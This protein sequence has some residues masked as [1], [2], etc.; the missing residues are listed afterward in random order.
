MPKIQAGAR[1]AEA[2]FFAMIPTATATGWQPGIRT[3][4]PVPPAIADSAS[5]RM[6]GRG[7][8]SY[9]YRRSTAV[10][11]VY[12]TIGG[13]HGCT[14]IVRRR[15]CV[16]AQGN[17]TG[18]ALRVN[19]VIIVRLYGQG[20]VNVF[21][22]SVQDIS[23]NLCASELVGPCKPGA[24]EA[25]HRRTSAPFCFASLLRLR[26]RA[27]AG[28]SKVSKAWCDQHRGRISEDQQI[29]NLKAQHFTSYDWLPSL[30][31]FTV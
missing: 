6:W 1:C 28:G 15:P 26:R 12:D 16:D 2:P 8:A 10:Q 17:R 25:P 19:L 27:F 20:G 3:R 21:I 9:G 22:E 13:D 29:Y 31:V 24:N 7:S 18:R 14:R 23:N 11:G 30:A 4:H 5:R